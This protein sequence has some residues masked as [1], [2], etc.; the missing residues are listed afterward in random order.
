VLC[1]VLD[2]DPARL[3]ELAAAVRCNARRVAI[4]KAAWA[5]ED[6]TRRLA[7]A[8]LGRA[9]LPAADVARVAVKCPGLLRD[10]A[11][12]DPAAV[13]ELLQQH[14]YPGAEEADG[15]GQAD[16]QPLAALLRRAPHVLCAPVA[17]VEANLRHLTATLGLPPAAV[18]RV[19]SKH[20]TLLTH[21]PGAM[22][23]NMGFLV[24]LG[25]TGADLRAMLARCP[26]W[27]TMPLHDLTVKWQFFRQDLKVGAWVGARGPW[28]AWSHVRAS[29]EGERGGRCLLRVAAAG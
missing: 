7:G 20:C 22:A 11:G 4:A 3:Q 8:L 9:G 16:G 13:L 10:V 29:A 27:A 19:V 25:A 17:V 12:M 21:K 24:G 1:S 2:L 18:R 5:G 14:A 26:R 15:G 28:E 23:I 6:A